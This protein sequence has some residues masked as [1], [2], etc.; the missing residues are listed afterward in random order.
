MDHRWHEIFRDKPE[1]MTRPPS[2]WEDQARPLLE[3]LSQPPLIVELAGRDSV[4]A[5]L[6]LCRQTKVEALLPTYAY[7]GTEYGP[8]DQ[9]EQALERLA[10]RLPREVKLLP[11]LV[12]G[13][14][15]LWRALCGRHGGELT[16]RHGFCPICVGCHLYLHAVRAPLARR[17][18]GAPVISG[19]RESHDGRIKINQVGPALDAYQALMA[20][21]GVEL[22]MPLRQV[23]RGEEIDVILG[24][25]WPEGGEQLG[26]VLSGNYLDLG[27][28][29]DWDPAGL[30][31]YLTEFALPLTR[32]ALGSLEQGQTPDYQALARECLAE[33]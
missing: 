1:M 14:P 24:L 8:W 6:A 10:S 21:Q 3:G 22:L 20:E 30:D 13:S 18:G 25:D 5:P 12:L 23:H 17:L 28:K 9:V 27:G 29:A 31:A 32:R 7:T 16:R 4:A 11:P 2:W 26:C 33:R 15:A 19:E